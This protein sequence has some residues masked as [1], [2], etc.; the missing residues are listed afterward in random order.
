ML[1]VA[2][3]VFNGLGSNFNATEWI[4]SFSSKLDEEGQEYL[5]GIKVNIHS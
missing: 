4:D 1:D 2:V 5:N 3:D